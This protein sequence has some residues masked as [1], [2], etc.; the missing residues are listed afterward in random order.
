MTLDPLSYFVY[1]ENHRAW[2]T[3]VQPGK[4]IR[5]FFYYFKKTFQ[6]DIFA[7]YVQKTKQF[8]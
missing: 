1:H 7:T 2:Q 4:L 6:I 3:Y 5:K 8:I